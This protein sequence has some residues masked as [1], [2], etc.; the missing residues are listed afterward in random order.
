MIKRATIL[1]IS[2][3]IVEITSIPLIILAAV[4]LISG[5]QM[6]ALEVRVIPEPRRVHVDKF[7]RILT[8]LLAYLHA[9]CGM[10]IIAERRIRTEIIRRIAEAAAIII[11]TALLIFSLTVEATILDLGYRYRWGART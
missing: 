6:L 11:L 9:V 10:I 3:L 2:L 5:Y 4:Y 7:L 1:R 8:V